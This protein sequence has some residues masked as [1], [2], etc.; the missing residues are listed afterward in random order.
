MYF[1]RIVIFGVGLIGGSIGLAVKKRRIAG[2]VIGV[3]DDP[4]SLNAALERHAIDFAAANL[5][6]GLN[7]KHP[8]AVRQSETGSPVLSLQPEAE[9]I[10]V[11][12]PVSLV[13]DVVWQAASAVKTGGNYRN[14]L[15]T[16]VGSTKETIC[17]RFES[18]TLPNGCRFIGSHPIAG[19]ETSGVQNADADLFENRLAVVTPTSSARDRDIGSLIRF[20]RSLGSVAAS[21]SPAEHDRIL[22]RT[23]HLPHLLSALL[24]DR[25]QMQDVRYTGPGYHSTTRLASGLPEMWRDIV[26]HNTESILEAI[27]DYEHALRNLRE[28]I[29]SGDW[30]AVE[31]FLEHAKRNRDGLTGSSRS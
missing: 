11:A 30:E 1:S 2:T 26:S 18:A 3:S 13:P 29:E 31:Q 22:A 24:A 15:I 16:D 5:D 19:K 23:S 25:L 12:V 4:E 21:M 6:E 17:S 8:A 28:K 7:T 10:V 9:L 14:V 20:W 27:R